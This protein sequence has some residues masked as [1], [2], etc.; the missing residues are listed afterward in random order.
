MYSFS[1]LRRQTSWHINRP[2]DHKQPT[3]LLNFTI[4]E[5]HVHISRYQWLKCNGTQGTPCPRL[6]F[7]AQSVPPPQIFIML[8]KDTPP[9]GPKPER[10]V[11]PPL[12]LHFNHCQSLLYTGKIEFLHI[13]MST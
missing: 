5:P 9:W 10:S 4:F 6:Q 2:T 13:T 7:M 12:I 1:H 11:P 3:D 8:G